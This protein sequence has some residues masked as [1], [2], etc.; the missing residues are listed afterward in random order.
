MVGGHG[1]GKASKDC[2]RICGTKVARK[3]ARRFLQNVRLRM[4]HEFDVVLSAFV[5]T[6]QISTFGDGT[7]QLSTFMGE[8]F[9]SLNRTH[10]NLI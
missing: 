2:I 8:K 9:T 10:L 4:R 6:M 7:G 5:V 1:C 3:L